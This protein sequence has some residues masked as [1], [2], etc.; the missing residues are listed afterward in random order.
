MKE[1]NDQ[2]RKKLDR[3][4]AQPNTDEAQPNRVEAQPN[5]VEAQ[6]Y[7]VDRYVTLETVL[8]YCGYDV[9]HTRLYI[10]R[11]SILLYD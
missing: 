6:P 4:E 8:C 7:K 9:F 11:N 5:T 1:K 10:D 3:V 2:N